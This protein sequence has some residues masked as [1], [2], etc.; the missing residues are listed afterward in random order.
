MITIN[1]SEEYGCRDWVAKLTEKEY[2]ELIT[3]WCTMRGLKCLVPVTLII[4]QAVET[5]NPVDSITDIRCHIHEC[6]DSY[7][8]G[9]NYNIPEDKFFW[10][11]GKKYDDKTLF[12]IIGT[13]IE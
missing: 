6:G 4:P 2:K 12:K 11:D 5:R 10:I 8:Q 9:C 7:L 3:R 13:W 1:I